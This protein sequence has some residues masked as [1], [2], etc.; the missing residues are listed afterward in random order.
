VYNND[1]S[2]AYAGLTL[3]GSTLYG[4]TEQ[5]GS[6]GDGVVFEVD[7][8]GSG[9]MNLYSFTNGTD[10]YNPDGGVVLS[11]HTLYG[12]AD[13]GGSAE[14]GTV[15]SLTLPVINL[16]QLTINRAGTNVILSWPTTAIGYALQSTTNL[17]TPVWTTI[18]GQY[19]VTNPIIDT[20]EF[21]RLLPP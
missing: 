3:S 19:N 5:G 1:G 20:N 21:Y 8:S 14:N 15:Y 2:H 6:T 13:Y 18:S 4:T 9:Y 17:A 10:G 16:P 11:G 12:T 7:V